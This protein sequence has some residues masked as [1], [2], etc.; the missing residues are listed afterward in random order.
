MGK[1]IDFPTKA[2]AE[3]TEEKLTPELVKEYKDTILL[4]HQM[5]DQIVEAED[6]KHAYGMVLNFNYLLLKHIEEMGE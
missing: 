2:K 5:Q 6:W 1:V 3:P 4:V